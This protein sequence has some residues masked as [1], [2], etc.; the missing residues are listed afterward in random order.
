[1]YGAT[2]SLL[3]GWLPGIGILFYFWA[4]ILAIFG[5]HELQEIAGDRAAF[6]AGIPPLPAPSQTYIPVRSTPEPD[7]IVVPGMQCQKL[8]TQ[9]GALP[10][11]GP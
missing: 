1:M 2:P 6:F 11:T 10:L 7:T 5:I 4:M 8:R 9:R 3:F